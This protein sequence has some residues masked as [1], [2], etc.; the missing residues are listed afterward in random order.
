MLEGYSQICQV[1]WGEDSSQLPGG[2]PAD[3]SDVRHKVWGSWK[4]LVLSWIS[5]TSLERLFTHGTY[6][7]LSMLQMRGDPGSRADRG[8]A[9]LLEQRL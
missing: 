9:G 5:M 8:S 1:S 4:W 3:R 2:G 7:V 6:Y